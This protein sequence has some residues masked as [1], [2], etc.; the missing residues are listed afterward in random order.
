VLDTEIE[1]LIR[2]HKIALCVPFRNADETQVWILTLRPRDV[3]A[4][5]V[6]M[7]VRARAT[8]SEQNSFRESVLASL[9]LLLLRRYEPAATAPS[10]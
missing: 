9:A 2:L 3:R 5:H 6:F 10:K 8:L 1:E 7:L 4:H